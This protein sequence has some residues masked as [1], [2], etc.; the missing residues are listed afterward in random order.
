M[1]AISGVASLAD[2][3]IAQFT[4]IKKNQLQRTTSMKPSTFLKSCLVI[5][6]AG[7]VCNQSDQ[8]IN[9]CTSF[10]QHHL[11]QSREITNTFCHK[12]PMGVV[13]VSLSDNAEQN[14]NQTK[15][16]RLYTV[17]LKRFCSGSILSYQSKTQQAFCTTCTHNAM[18]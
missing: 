10:R 14:S 4:V 3:L 9:N 16:T 15:L 13:R 7:Q 17:H 11:W 6:A 12:F 8:A 5:P 1:D 18:F 2:Y